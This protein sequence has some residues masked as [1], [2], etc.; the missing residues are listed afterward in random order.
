MERKLGEII[1]YKEVK[2]KIVK[3]DGYCTNCFFNYQGHCLKPENLGKCNGREDKLDVIFKEIKESPLTREKEIYKDYNG[4]N[5]PNIVYWFPKPE[6]P[7][8]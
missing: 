8:E 5:I 1:N 3:G 7:K 4:W 6:L 2:L